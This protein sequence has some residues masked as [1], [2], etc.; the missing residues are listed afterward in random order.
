MGDS[1]KP[2][3]EDVVDII[4]ILDQHKINYHIHYKGK[5]L[6]LTFIR[7][8]DSDTII[9]NIIIS[10]ENIISC[11]ISKKSSG[12]LSKCFKVG[13]FGAVIW[14]GYKLYQS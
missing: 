2:K 9:N 8:D 10:G 11:N 7:D 3:Y 13:I 1:G 12:I 4:N 5:Q 14:G 6:I